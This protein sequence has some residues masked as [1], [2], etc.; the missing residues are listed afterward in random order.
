MMPNEFLAKG[1][2]IVISGPTNI[3]NKAQK[4]PPD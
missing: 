3:P 1:T 4:N 2:E